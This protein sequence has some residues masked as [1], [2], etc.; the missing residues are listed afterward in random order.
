[1]KYIEAVEFPMQIWYYNYSLLYE[2]K[3]D[4]ELFEF[5]FKQRKQGLNILNCKYYSDALILC[6]YNSA[7]DAF[8]ILFNELYIKS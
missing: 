1:M 3:F 6:L 8:K 4:I 5:F 2:S 7:S